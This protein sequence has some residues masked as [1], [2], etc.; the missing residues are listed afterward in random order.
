VFPHTPFKHCPEQHSALPAHVV[1]ISL[2]C[3]AVAP[4]VCGLPEHTLPQQSDADVHAVPSARHG[5]VQYP[6]PLVPK[7]LQ[8]PR[9]QSA[10]VV[11]SAPTGRHGPGPKSQ[12]VSSTPGVQTPLQQFPQSW[13]VAPH[14]VDEWHLMPPSKPGPQL[15]EQH[16]AF[17]A[18]GS[19]L[20]L[21]CEPP[22]VP[23]LH[24]IEQHSSAEAHAA[25]SALQ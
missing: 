22:H 13:P 16:S 19:S 25:P 14:G 12:R 7:M 24:A 10:L 20:Y 17:V 15:P 2:H 21:Q 8:V 18:H 5:A 6:A 1:P 11:Q 9:Q 4:H 23:P 3:T